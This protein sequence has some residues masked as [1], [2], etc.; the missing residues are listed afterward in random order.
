MN[1][2][3]VTKSHRNINWHLFCFWKNQEINLKHIKYKNYATER[4]Y[5]GYY[6]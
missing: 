2:N 5:W 1:E 6:G 4:P 3:I